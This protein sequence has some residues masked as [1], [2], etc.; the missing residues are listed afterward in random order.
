MTTQATPSS[1]VTS[2]SDFEQLILVCKK[3]KITSL[4]LGD[5][6]MQIPSDVKTERDETRSEQQ[7]D[8]NALAFDT[9]RN[10]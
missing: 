6:E 9:Y 2:I 4:K 1:I 7:P 3:H 5:I 10:L 8:I